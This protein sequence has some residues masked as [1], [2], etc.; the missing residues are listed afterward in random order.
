MSWLAGVDVGGTFTDIVLVNTETHEVLVAKTPTT[1]RNQSESFLRGLSETGHLAQVDAIVHGTT[2]GT[3]AILER[4]GATTGII[5]SRG[6]RDV[7]ELGRRTRPANYG[8]TGEF[9]PLVSREHRIEVDERID[10]TGNVHI[11]LD[12][13]GVA[14]AA[15]ALRNAGV[16][17]IAVMF[18]HSYANPDHEAEA[19]AVIR[20][21]WPDAHV[22]L[23][24]R[25]L[26]EAG[27][28]ERVSTT[29]INA[30]L[31]PLMQRYVDS[32]DEKLRDVGYEKSFRIMQSNG[33]ALNVANSVRFSC[34]SVLSGPAG[35]A[36][37]TAWIA[38][39]LGIAHAVSADMGGT[40]FDVSVILDGRP[41]LTEEKELTYGIP[42]RVPMIDIE[43]IGAGGGS[44]IWVDEVGMIHVGPESAGADPGPI[45]Y[46][47]G[48]TRPTVTDANVIL[49]RLDVRNVVSAGA[50][51]MAAVRR[52]FAE[53]G[54]ALGTTPEEAAEA[55]LKITDLLMAG[56]ISKITLEKGLD[57][58][59]FIML[60]FG[61]AGPL[62]S[63]SIADQLGIEKVLLPIWPGVNSALGCLLADVRTD[64]T[65]S[66][67]QRLD[68]VNFE[69]ISLLYAG[70]KTR[71]TETMKEDGVAESDIDWLYEASFQYEG[72]VHR[73]ML[74]VAFDSSRWNDAGGDATSGF[75][76]SWANLF[77]REYQKRYGVHAEGV[78]IVLAA[79]RIRASA[80]RSVGTLLEKNLS[81]SS[82]RRTVRVGDLPITPTRIMFNGTWHDAAV[83]RR[84]AM[85]LDD[86]IVGP[87][88]LD[89]QDTTTFI[90][91]GWFA[92]MDKLGYVLISKLTEYE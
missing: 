73:I 81:T 26:P 35:G 20:E 22:S 48:G 62:H 57:A 41:S 4:K 90:P 1:V 56:A 44:I 76:S 21:V 13:E 12:R 70:M 16:Q 58:R 55:A 14:T 61:G 45:S 53:I 69:R 50:D 15:I 85:N 83:C 40:S 32:V 9:Q 75:L 79:L 43:T 28:F 25:V 46:G 27:E 11:R 42:T 51:H 47:R 19:A 77:E 60:P 7:I 78:P 59:K 39:Q 36:I 49:G 82:S 3:N 88:R 6:F 34:R 89:Q 17:S 87:A 80:S 52:A 29:A 74:E 65:W 23:S 31:Q 33:G 38:N 64:E 37:A 92:K 63:C 54:S 18:M 68:S 66:V 24:H 86:I 67:L 2:V 10:A 71:L 8:L 91:P 84:E 5:T 72:Q 30:Y